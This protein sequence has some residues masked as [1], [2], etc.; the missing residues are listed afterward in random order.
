MRGPAKA[1][2][3][4]GRGRG[5]S[6][7]AVERWESGVKLCQRDRE[8]CKEGCVCVCKAGEGVRTGRVAQRAL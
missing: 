1:G 6:C 8:P 2:T 4:H 7:K 3:A 5:G